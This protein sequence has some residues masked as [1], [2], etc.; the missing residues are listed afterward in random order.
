MSKKRYY[1]TTTTTELDYMR[2]I[3]ITVGVLVILG[4]VYLGTAILSGEINFKKEKKEDPV[5]TI[6]YSTIVAGETFN[7]SPI[8]YYVLFYKS[9]D[10]F[11]EYYKQ[12]VSSYKYTAESLPFY[13]VDL[14]D[15][16]NEEYLINDEDANK[17]GTPSD[18]S[19]L[20]VVAPT[21][22]RIRNKQVFDYIVGKD[23]ILNFFNN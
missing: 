9:S 20:K 17:Y 1:K 7:R 8:D 13:F 5:T 10:S 14:D 6:E 4:L 19:N 16:V 18:I 22:I 15:K 3:K 2:V 21:I 11:A 12:L 23:N